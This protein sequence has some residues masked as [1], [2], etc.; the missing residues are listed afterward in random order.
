MAPLF[1]LLA[2]APL[3]AEYLLGNLTF[4]QMTLFPLMM[5]FYGAGAVFIREVTRRSGRG[6]P[7]LLTLGLA[8]GVVEEAISTQSLFNP[9]YMGFHLL[10]VGYVPALG[11]AVPWTVYV[12]GLHAVWSIAVPIALVESLYPARRRTPWVGRVGMCVVGAVFAVGATAVA[13]GSRRMDSFQASGTQ[14]GFSFLFVGA[15]AASAFLLFRRAAPAVAPP[16][17]P[18]A[19]RASRPWALGLLAFAC[20]SA[21]HF[22]NYGS[23]RRISAVAIVCIEF[24]PI[25]IAW[26]AIARASRSPGWTDANTDAVAT[27]ALLVYCWWGFVLAYTV[28]GPA[29]IP[30]Q[31]FPASVV[32]ALLAYRHLARRPPQAPNPPPPG[33]LRDKELGSRSVA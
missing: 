3:I 27:G 28:H 31:C 8:Y 14:M 12:L 20:G 18:S 1:T 5:I 6:W 16:S 33:D 29:A 11:I 10:D 32:L 9:H 21:F 24:V 30:G 2:L 7:T 23:S 4:G 15:I 26:A 22:F 19:G 17:D 25:A 13:L